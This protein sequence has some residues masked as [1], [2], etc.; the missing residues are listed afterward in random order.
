M[1]IDPDGRWVPLIAA[2][3]GGALNFATQILINRAV[4]GFSWQKGIAPA[5]VEKR[6]AALL[7]LSR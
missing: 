3:T 4:K 1:H 7:A 5:N 6:E 2:I